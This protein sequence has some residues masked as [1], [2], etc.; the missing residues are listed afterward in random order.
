MP[1]QRK[2]PTSTLTGGVRWFVRVTR[3]HNCACWGERFCD[4]PGLATGITLPITNRKQPRAKHVPWLGCTV[5]A[6]L[7]ACRTCAGS[8]RAQETIRV[9]PW[10]LVLRYWF[11]SI[12][13]LL[14]SLSI[15]YPSR[16]PTWPDLVGRYN[17]FFVLPLML[18]LAVL[19]DS[20]HLSHQLEV[21]C[22]PYSASSL[23]DSLPSFVRE[24]SLT[25]G[26]TQK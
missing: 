21:S 9:P 25:V 13:F 2:Q 24:Y 8:A 20:L 14:W 23:V 22:R 15:T 12:L 3:W 1:L 16:F 19:L 5:R 26:Y 7:H 10:R 4:L 11:T 6:Q 17:S 18:G